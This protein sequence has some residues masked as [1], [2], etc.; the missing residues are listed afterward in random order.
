V[1]D[2]LIGHTVKFLD[3]EVGFLRYGFVRKA[4]R[5]RDEPRMTARGRRIKRPTVPGYLVELVDGTS[6]MVRDY[7]VRYV[8][9]YDR[10]ITVMEFR[11]KKGA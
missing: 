7:E 6:R 10:D 4:K 2:P 9:F 5:V 8:R 11:A 3:R 1:K